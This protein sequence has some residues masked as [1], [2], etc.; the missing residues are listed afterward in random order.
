MLWKAALVIGQSLGMKENKMTP[1][2]PGAI[3]E[4]YISEE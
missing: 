2:K 1:G 4:S 3:L